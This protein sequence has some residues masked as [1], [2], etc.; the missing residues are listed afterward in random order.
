MPD[1]EDAYRQ[2]DAVVQIIDS[3]G[4]AHI[5]VERAVHALAAV[6]SVSRCRSLLLGIVLQD[7]AGRAD[8]VGVDLRAL[9][10]SWYF[11]VIALLGTAAD[12]DRL[13][14]D[15]RYWKNELAKA[16][17]GVESE[18]GSVS[19]F[20]V[21]QRAKRADELLPEVDEAEGKAV[22]WYRTIYAIE[23]L[24]N[25]HASLETLKPYLLEED[26]GTIGI[27]HEPQIDEGL[28]YGRI[29]IAAVL[30][31]LLAKWTWARVGLDPEPFDEIEGLGD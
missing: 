8:I 4:P 5:P 26:D 13:E 23:S 22:E 25:S 7:Q 2:A 14:E 28:R 27:V 6:A 1:I 17:P 29:R 12:L 18:S 3:A 21:F 31:S 20:P 19:K 11:G 16:L 24:T 30:T 15:H 9:L 10:E